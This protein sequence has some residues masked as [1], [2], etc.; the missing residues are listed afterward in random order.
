M[1]ALVGAEVRSM[2]AEVVHLTEVMEEE[3]VV[4]LALMA[5]VVHLSEVTEEEPVVLSV[6]TV[7]VVQDE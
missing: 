3:L 4:L 6:S 1:R 7:E 2:K 5:E